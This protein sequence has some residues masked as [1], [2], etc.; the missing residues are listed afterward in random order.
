MEGGARMNTNGKEEKGAE[1]FGMRN[2]ER[3]RLW[4]SEGLE[5]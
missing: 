4:S 3:G 5:F 2:G 1:K